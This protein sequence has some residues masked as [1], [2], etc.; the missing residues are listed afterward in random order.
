MS[1]KSRIAVDWSKTK[2]YRMW[3][4]EGVCH[5]PGCGRPAVGFLRYQSG[6]ECLLCESHEESFYADYLRVKFNAG[7][8][9]RPGPWWK[10]RRKRVD[11]PVAT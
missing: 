3:V 5:R 7:P 11:S 10:W 2:I 4:P 9:S 6:R 1:T 8:D